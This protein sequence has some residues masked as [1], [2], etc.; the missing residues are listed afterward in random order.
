MDSLTAETQDAVRPPQTRSLRGLRSTRSIE[1]IVLLLVLAAL[2]FVL[3]SV[4][5]NG[6][7]YYDDQFHLQQCRLI[8]TQQISFADYVLLPHGE[9]FIPIWKALFCG[10]YLAFGES[11]LAFHLLVTAFHSAAVLL[12]YFLLRSYTTD[13]SAAAAS[14]IWALAAIGGWDGPFLWIAASHLSVG[15]TFILAAMCCVTKLNS[16]DHSR[17]AL[18]FGVLLTLG[19]FT[20]GSLIVLMPALL[21]QYWLFEHQQRSSNQSLLWWL[22]ALAVPCMA[23]VAVHLLYVLPAVE[24][25][26]RPAMN[27]IAALQM[28][29]G[30]YAIASWRLVSWADNAVF[31]GRLFGLAL[32][33][34][35]LLL[36]SSAER[37]SSL[38]FF[39]VSVFFSLLA[40]TARSGWEVTH[41]LSWG[42]YR[43]L[44]TL[45]WCVVAGIV[46]AAGLRWLREHHRDLVWPSVL[47]VGL[48]VLI[49]QFRIAVSSAEVFRRIAAE[50]RRQSLVD[51]ATPDRANRQAS[52]RDS[53]G[54]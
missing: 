49:V 9:H 39:T 50:E 23:V 37:R 11:S 10:C 35:L 20:M 6:G 14:I 28:L 7:F 5:A 13:L 42:R 8:E 43:Y 48:F 17:W 22:P 27:P 34:A 18:L 16:P 45:F 19:L 15:V 41:V 2:P 24:R 29:S 54:I 53:T 46:A 33:T 36:G 44:P 26:D 25:L 12:L 4:Y 51:V 30:G 32:L 38:L 52:T 31:W 47:S 40:Y 1:S 21:L 3:H